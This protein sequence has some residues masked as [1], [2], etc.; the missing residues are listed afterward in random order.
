[1]KKGGGKSFVAAKQDK[2]QVIVFKVNPLTTKVKVTE[3]NSHMVKYTY[4]RAAE[5]RWK[6]IE[7]ACPVRSAKKLGERYRY[8][9]A[10]LTEPDVEVTDDKGAK[11]FLALDLSRFEGNIGTMQKKDRQ[12]VERRSEE[13]AVADAALWSGLKSTKHRNPMGCR[14]FLFELFAGLML[15]SATV[16]SAGYVISQPADIDVDGATCARPV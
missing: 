9:I 14:T 8:M 5:G 16:A 4:V 3:F 11:V 12:M 10:F 6:R 2:S 15:L 1:M 13:I 7:S